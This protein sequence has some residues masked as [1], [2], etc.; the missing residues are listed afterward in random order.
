MHP[1]VYALALLAGLL[2]LQAIL[3]L[4][5]PRSGLRAATR[6]RL[7]RLATHLAERDD[8]HGAS[9]LRAEESGDWVAWLRQHL[10]R[11]RRLD[12]L[13]CRAGAPL[14]ARQFWLASAALAGAGLIAG[15]AFFGPGLRAL[16][17]GLTGAIPLLVLLE[18]ER[19]RMARLEAQ[20]PDAL[21]LIARALRAGHSLSF[22][23][24]MV[25]DELP[26]PVGTEFGQAARQIALGLEPRAAISGIAARLRSTDIAFFVT[27]V[28]IQR[29]TGGNLAEILENLAHVIRE[30]FKMYGKVRALTAQTRMSANILMAMPFVMVGLLSLVNPGYTEPLFE[31]ESGRMLML[32]AAAMLGIGYWLCRRLGVVRI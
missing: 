22:G 21:E 27:A 14:S 29:E 19:R 10:P 20:L 30:R 13:L 31:T 6:R 24:Q 8:P 5:R 3:A 23:L 12:A 26:D 7:D 1:G 18:L 15:F 2:G 16:A 28:L 11:S 25:A 9:L 4:G 17:P 32:V